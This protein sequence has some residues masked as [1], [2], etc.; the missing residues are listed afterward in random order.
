MGRPL[1]GLKRFPKQI[2]V[3]QQRMAVGKRPGRL[4][5]CD[6]LNVDPGNQLR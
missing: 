1:V 6:P 3:S 5:R 4:C 2:M